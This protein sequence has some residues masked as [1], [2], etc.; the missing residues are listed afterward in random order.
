M[1]NW[2]LV[3]AGATITPTLIDEYPGLTIT[4]GASAH[5]LGAWVELTP[6]LPW[7][8]DAID[9]SMHTAANDDP[10]TGLVDIGIGAAGSETV[11]V[12]EL[13]FGAWSFRQNHG[14]ASIGGRI[15]AGVRVAARWRSSLA[16]YARRVG[17]RFHGATGLYPVGGRVTAHSTNLATSSGVLVSSTYGSDTIV[18][19]VASAPAAVR[20]LMIRTV[21][22]SGSQDG[23]VARVWVGP[24]GAE[25]LLSDYLPIVMPVGSFVM[26]VNLP[27]GTRIGISI[28]NLALTNLAA[29]AAYLVH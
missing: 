19:L 9:V 12:P 1:S 28:R 16:N 2:P 20:Q 6:G 17:V 23:I 29:M 10:W 25:T 8:A 26:P 27:A 13:L 14:I 3:R 5:T 11:I 24:G 21:P 22:A 7:P 18:E 15:P 4:S